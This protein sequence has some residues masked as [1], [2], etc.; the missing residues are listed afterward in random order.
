MTNN[1]KNDGKGK[2]GRKQR[3][4]RNLMLATIVGLIVI[5]GGYALYHFSGNGASQSSE[6]NHDGDSSGAAAKDKAA[7]DSGGVKAHFNY[8]A[9][10]MLGN[11]DAPVKIVEF[12]DYRCSVCYHFD[13]KFF[14]KL[15]K[16]FIETGKAS[17]YFMN[18]PILGQ[19]SV[20]AALASESVFRRSPEAFWKYHE[21]VYDHQG[22]EDKEWATTD[23]LVRL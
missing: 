20:R 19:G 13:Q 17:F 23:F 22:P 1:Q 2:T 14:P 5:F 18:Y 11:E 12:G 9:Q 10:P 8:D 15:K 4:I 16:Q 7:M 6:Q 3:Q 21:T